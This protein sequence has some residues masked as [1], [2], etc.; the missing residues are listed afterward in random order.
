M[1][2][3]VT[4]VDD[5][6]SILFSISGY[7]NN[8]KFRTETAPNL[9]EAKKLMAAGTA[10]AVILDM[11]LPDG[12]GIEWIPELR[13]RFPSLAIIMIT[14]AGDIPMAV[15]AMQK[16]A[17]TFLTKPI[18]LNELEVFLDKSLELNS[19]RRSSLNEKRLQK[20]ISP[21]W[22]ETGA[23][24]HV[25]KLVDIAAGSNSPILLLGETGTGK[26]VLA[27][28]IHNHSRQSNAAFVEIN[29][30]SL[31]G[32][33]LSSE[34]FGHRKGAFTSAVDDK[35]GLIEV[36]HRG[37]LFLDE[38][39]DLD[40]EIQTQLLKVIEEKQ[41]RRLGDVETRKSD[42]RLLCATNRD[43]VKDVEDKKFR[44][45]LFYRINVFPVEIPP[46]RERRE[47]IEPMI[48]YLLKQQGREMKSLRP[49]LLRLL[50]KYSWPGNIREMRN[51]LERALLLAGDQDLVPEH[52]PG[53]Y[54]NGFK[55]PETVAAAQLESVEANHIRKILGAC[56]DDTE[57]AAKILGI[58][59]ASLYRKIQKHQLK[60]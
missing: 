2:P 35:Q 58:S 42:F 44:Q 51:V 47:D 56:S 1:R 34:L 10:D 39:G 23:M 12:N 17:D 20:T 27:H 3:V 5:D 40:F 6:P 21:F 31:K 4:I 33:L 13:K 46:V 19:L 25:K 36:A 54:S 43:L 59:R 8:L 24:N 41:F 60:S 11:Q 14:G 45:D 15:E 48:L 22:G 32:E 26:G 9:K 30:T 57:R 55:P 28:W 53:I 18:D 29:C 38:I 37:T 16:G 7:L 49:A 52:F 50:G